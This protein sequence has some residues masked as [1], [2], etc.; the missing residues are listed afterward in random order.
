MLNPDQDSIDWECLVN[1]AITIIIPQLIKVI[2][3]G[4]DLREGGGGSSSCV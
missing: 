1:N 4:N 2:M 3:A